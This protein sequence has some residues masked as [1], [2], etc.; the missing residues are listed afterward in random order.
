MQFRDSDETGWAGLSW[1]YLKPFLSK[2]LNFINEQT[3]LDMTKNYINNF[4]NKII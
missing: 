4:Y 2:V 3:V 1:I